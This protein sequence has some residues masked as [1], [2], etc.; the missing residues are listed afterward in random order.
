MQDQKTIF[1]IQKISKLEFHKNS[2]LKRLLELPDKIPENIYFKGSFPDENT[3]YL[4]IVGSRNISTYGKDVLDFLFKDLQGYNICIISGLATGVDSRAHELALKYN[5]K[6]IS[7][8]GSGIDEKVLYPSTNRK[9]M[10]NI[11]ESGGLVLNEFEPDFKATLWSFPMRNRIMAML[12]DALLVVEASEKSGSLITVRLATDY[13]KDILTIP[14][15]IFSKNS[16]G[17]NNLIKDGAT[18]VTSANDILETLKIKPREE[19]EK[20]KEN[21]ESLNLTDLE[22]DILNILNEPITKDKIFEKL[23]KYDLGEI[24]TALTLLEWKGFVKEEVG[25]VRRVR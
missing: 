8:P 17:P 15:N 23:S 5:L 21:L 14:G 4:A 16:F 22:K 11:L 10:Q 2:L 6:T 1:P 24:L 13:N 20:D 19:I 12:C 9:L 18:P 3:K 25:V 7:V